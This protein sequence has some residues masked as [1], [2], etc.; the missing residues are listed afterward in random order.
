MSGRLLER[1][2]QFAEAL[3][4]GGRGRAWLDHDRAD[5]R[6]ERC[7]GGEDVEGDL[8][9]VRERGAVE[10]ADAGVSLEVVTRVGGGDRRGD[11]DPDCSPDLLVRVQQPGGD[12]GVV[13]RTPVSP[14]IEIGTNAK[15]RPIP[16]R[17]KAGNR[18][19]K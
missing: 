16:L 1:R 12:A 11:G 10:R 7:E 3:L 4:C 15:A 13:C 8:E 18:F 5:H 19:A 6:R 9:A 17:M 2:G 14:P